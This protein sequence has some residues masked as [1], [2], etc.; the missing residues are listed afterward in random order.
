V[1]GKLTTI[2]R[3]GGSMKAVYNEHPLFSYTGDTGTGQNRGNGINA[4]GGVWPEVTVPR[5]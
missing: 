2:T 5:N 4:S 1:S 3:S